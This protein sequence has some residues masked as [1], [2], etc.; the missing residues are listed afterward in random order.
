MK[1]KIKVA[2]IAFAVTTMVGCS[3]TK[4]T[5]PQMT[6]EEYK[7]YKQS[8]IDAENANK[9]KD[10]RVLK[11]NLDAI[12][13]FIGSTGS[14][15]STYMQN[16]DNLNTV[17]YAT[18]VINND[19]REDVD[20]IM[21]ELSQSMTSEQGINLSRRVTNLYFEYMAI[22]TDISESKITPDLNTRISNLNKDL[23][24]LDEILTEMNNNQ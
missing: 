2:L 1:K 22:L 23:N 4:T 7:E 14:Q 11:E 6:E 15:L 19:D 17:A 12:S 21:T 24:N 13:S 3:T 9:A 16:G 10:A 8:F 5:K 20:E 18:G